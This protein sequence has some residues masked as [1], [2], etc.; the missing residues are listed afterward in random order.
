MDFRTIIP[1]TPSAYALQYAHQL[2]MIGS[3]FTESI[4]ERLQNAKFK[5]DVNPFGILYNPISIANSLDKLIDKQLFTEKELFHSNDQYHSFSHHSCFSASTPTACL[6]S[7]NE[8]LKQSAKNLQ[9]ADFLFITFGTAWV[10][11]LKETGQIVSNCHKIPDSKFIRRRL[12]VEEIVS[13]YT[14][15]I[16]QINKSTNQQII[17][18]VSPIRHWKDGAHENNVSKSVLLLAIEELKQQFGSISYFPAYELV[19]DDLRDYRFYAEDMFHPNAV[20]ID[21]IWEKFGACYFST[22]TQRTASEIEKLKR[23]L[24]HRP[25]NKAGEEYKQFCQQTLNKIKQLELVYPDINFED[26]KKKLKEINEK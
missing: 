3:C 12:T 9:E 1:V 23:A 11:E 25:F 5:V 22:E 26:E 6:K 4:G 13:V 10:Y 16:Q 21:Y 14:K 17:F 19:L 8:R 7:I 15:L 24:A 18:T 20:A 2:T